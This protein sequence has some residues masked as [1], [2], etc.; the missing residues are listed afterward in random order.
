ML[1]LYLLT[2]LCSFHNSQN[3]NNRQV[4]V[5]DH[6]AVSQLM[7]IHDTRAAGPH[8]KCQETVLNILWTADCVTLHVMSSVGYTVYFGFIH[9]LELF[10]TKCKRCFICLLYSGID[11]LSFY[12]YWLIDWFNNKIE[13]WMS[14]RQFELLIT[15]VIFMDYLGLCTCDPHLKT[16]NLKTWREIGGTDI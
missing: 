7:L 5:G 16:L 2:T 13:L 10:W 4:F 12:S 11:C 6:F 8:K 15:V 3:H 14:K 1:S 9:S